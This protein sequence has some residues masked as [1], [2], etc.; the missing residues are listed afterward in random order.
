MDG[1]LF[2]EI[3]GG[4]AA[5][6]LHHNS[7]EN[8]VDA[9]HPHNYSPEITNSS[10]SAGEV[11]SPANCR[12][13]LSA[14][15]WKAGGLPLSVVCRA[16]A[17]GDL[18]GSLR[19]RL[20]VAAADIRPGGLEQ[21]GVAPG[22]AAAAGTR[23]GGTLV[24]VVEDVL[25]HE[26]EVLL[27]AQQVALGGGLHGGGGGQVGVGGFAAPV[28]R[29]AAA[30]VDHHAHGAQV[31]L[32]VGGVELGGD[33]FPALGLVLDDDGAGIGRGAVLLL[34][35][36]DLVGGDGD[37][38]QEGAHCPVEADTVFEHAGVALQP[39]D[40]GGE[41]GFAQ[42]GAQR[43]VDGVVQADGVLGGGVGVGGGEPGAAPRHPRRAR[44]S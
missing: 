38:P 43:A 16:L 26:G 3:I 41:I 1:S 44:C 11:F 30:G 14:R 34:L 9:E 37:Q 18:A 15:R 25:Q 22:R 13:S 5:N 35:F 19:Q 32:G 21:L 27:A 12:K 40:H 20:V 39:G 31:V 7:L 6:N 10:R 42:Q 36:H 17:L 8:D 2:L 33:G 28:G 24:G 23:S 4:S 29:V